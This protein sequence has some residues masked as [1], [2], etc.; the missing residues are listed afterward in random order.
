MRK[1]ASWIFFI[2]SRQIT[3]LVFSRSMRSKIERRISRKSQST[4]RT[5]Q[6]EQQADDVVVDAADDDAVQRIGAADL[7]AV[8][9]IDV[10][11]HLR[12]E[13]REL[14]RVVLRVAVGV[15]D[16]LLGRGSE[17]GLQRAAVAA[18]LRMVDD[19]DAAGRSARARRRSRRVASALP[20]LTTM[21]SKSGVSS[22]AA[23]TARIT[24]LAMVPLSLYAGKK[25]LRPAGFSAGEADM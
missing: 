14:G 21:T 10:G 12:P 15:E 5:L 24:M 22:D 3:P 17:A 4:S 7:V 23:W 9:Q 2:I 25:T 8:H 16:Q 6:A 18:V 19:A 11:R 13:H 20:S 1:P